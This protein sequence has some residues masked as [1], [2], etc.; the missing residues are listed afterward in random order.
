MG[1]G[2]VRNRFRQARY[3]RWKAALVVKRAKQQATDQ[4]GYDSMPDLNT[5]ESD[6]DPLPGNA[7]DD[8]ELMELDENLV[9]IQT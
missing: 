9:V 5:S 8:P 2:V 1:G 6:P 3:D 4:S 7:D